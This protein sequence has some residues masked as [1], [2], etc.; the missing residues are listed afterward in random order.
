[1]CLL[2]SEHLSPEP[3]VGKSKFCLCVMGHYVWVLPKDSFKKLRLFTSF[4]VGVMSDLKCNVFCRWLRSAVFSLLFIAVIMTKLILSPIFF[5]KVFE[6]YFRFFFLLNNAI[7]YNEKYLK[8]FVFTQSKKL[9]WIKHAFL[10]IWKN[11]YWLYYNQYKVFNTTKTLV[12]RGRV[13]LSI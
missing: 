4:N 8:S 5:L 6:L 13:K 12:I 2:F 9:F 10:L 3:G 11:M 7:F 1:M